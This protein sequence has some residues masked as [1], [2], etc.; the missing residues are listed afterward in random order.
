MEA[1]NERMTAAGWESQG[2]PED[3]DEEFNAGDEVFAECVD[4]LA[5]L[6]EDFDAEEFP[7]QIAA[8][9]SDEFTY[10][11]ATDGPATT[12]E[13]SLDVTEETASAFIASVDDANVATVTQYIEVM[14][15]KDTGDCI[16]QGDGGGDGGGV[17]GLRRSRRV[18]PQ[19]V[20]RSRSWASE[21]TVRRSAL[22]CRR[23]SSCRSPSTPR[24]CSP[25]RAT[26]S[27]VSP[28]SSRVTSASGFDPRA[29][30]ADDRRFARRLTRPRPGSTRAVVGTTSVAVS[31]ERAR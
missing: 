14:G 31:Q 17:R 25:R 15:A 20:D 4:G 2:P 16:R 29:R 18:R 3:E 23:C 21:T 10:A 26:T 1:F 7:G 6:F 13:F 19:R 24:S 12:E 22:S 28:T 5:D 9:T 30:V 8:S 27:S 11:P